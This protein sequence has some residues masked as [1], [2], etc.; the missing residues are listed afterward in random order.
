MDL[1]PEADFIPEC[2]YKASTKQKRLRLIK[3]NGAMLHL[4]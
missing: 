4:G 3:G 1:T 2:D